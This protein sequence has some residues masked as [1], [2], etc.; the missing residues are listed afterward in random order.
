MDIVEKNEF[1]ISEKVMTHIWG[2][3]WT[4][5]IITEHKEFGDV[6][7]AQS[8]GTEL[9]EEKYPNEKDR[10][11]RDDAFAKFGIGIGHVDAIVQDNPKLSK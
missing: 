10:E 4:I 7:K 8:R 5:V 1:I 11:A 6:L 3:G 2:P 9:Y